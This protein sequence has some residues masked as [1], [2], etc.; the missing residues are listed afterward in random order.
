MNSWSRQMKALMSFH[1]LARLALATTPAA[2]A[3]PANIL[4][5]VDHECCDGFGLCRD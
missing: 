3:R 5:F 1:P 2:G 4:D